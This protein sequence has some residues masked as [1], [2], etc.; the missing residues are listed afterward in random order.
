MPQSYSFA[1]YVLLF[2]KDAVKPLKIE[3]SEAMAFIVSG[4]LS[5]DSS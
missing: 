4:G 3:S 5:G 2:P 1:G